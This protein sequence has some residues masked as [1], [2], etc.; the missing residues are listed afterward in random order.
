MTGVASWPPAF[1]AEVERDPPPGAP[2]L[3]A[4]GGPSFL[5]RTAETAIWIDP[6][7]GDTPEGL[8]EGIFRSLAIPIDSSAISRADAVLSTHAHVDHCHRET[9]LPIVANTQARCVAPSSSAALMREWSIPEERLVEVAAGAS[10]RIGDVSVQV[11]GAHDPMEPGAVTFVLEA[12]GVSLFVSGD[13]RLAPALSDVAAEHALDYALLAFG[14]DWYMDADALIEA[15]TVLNPTTL[16]PFHLEL[17]RRQTGD[18]VALFEAYHRLRPPF[19][20]AFPLI[21]DCL[22]LNCAPVVSPAS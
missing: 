11:Y 22:P 9:L 19:R 15:A 6:W 16:I 20:L 3:W 21:G 8:P 7:F 2:V 10:L 4:L 18:L 1:L 17:W 12:A 14:G 13:T 5:Y